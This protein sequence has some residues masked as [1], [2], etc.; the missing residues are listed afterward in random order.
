MSRFF[1]TILPFCLAAAS[2]HAN[3][4]ISEDPILYAVRP[5]VSARSEFAALDHIG[6]TDEAARTALTMGCISRMGMASKY[7]AQY[8][9]VQNDLLT[10]PEQKFFAYQLALCRER[11]AEQCFA[12]K[13]PADFGS[14]FIKFLGASF[15]INLTEKNSSVARR[16]VEEE[17]KARS[18]G[19]LEQQ[20]SFERG[21]KAI[22]DAE[23]EIAFIM[24]PTEAAESI[25]A[26]KSP[27]VRDAI[28]SILA[29]QEGRSKEAWKNLRPE[30]VYALLVG[31][32]SAGNR[33]NFLQGELRSLKV[34]SV[35]FKGHCVLADLTLEVV[36]QTAGPKT[37][38]VRASFTVFKDGS[39]R[40]L[41][42]N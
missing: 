33:W 36:G 42:N 11:Q 5:A 4:A 37:L 14:E 41:G 23:K 6:L 3:L 20:M 25:F 22:G 28:E 30:Q 26:M 35:A 15:A 2:A 32:S 39:I 24:E 29:E 21:I 31:A 34:E 19:Y 18:Y 10:K 16:A 38:R 8:L 40:L 12:L 1:A 7:A 9:F 17:L 27:R 13:P